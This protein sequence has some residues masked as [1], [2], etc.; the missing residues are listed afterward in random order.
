MEQSRFS[1]P[2]LWSSLA[3]QVLVILVTLGVIDTGLSEAIT[4][5][6]TSLLQLLVA[7]GVLNN[8]TSKSSF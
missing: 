7:F 2:I 4:G 5:L 8:P 6:V 3:A 1:S